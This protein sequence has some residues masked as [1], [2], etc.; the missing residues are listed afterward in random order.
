MQWTDGQESPL[1]QQLRA[2]A[3]EGQ[4]SIKFNVDGFDD[5]S[6][7]PTFTW[8]RIVGSIGPYQAGEPKHFVAARYLQPPG[9]RLA[10]EQRTVLARLGEQDAVRGP[11]QQ[12]ADGIGRRAAGGP[13][14]ARV[15]GSPIGG[16]LQVAALPANGDPG[17][18]GDTGRPGGFYEY[19]A[20]I[21]SAALSDVQLA[22][23][24]SEPNR[25]RRQPGAITLLAENA[26][27]T[28]LR[29]DDF[30][31][32]DGPERARQHRHDDAVRDQT[33]VPASGVEIDVWHNDVDE[34]GQVKQGSIAGMPRSACRP[35]RSPSRTRSRPA[36]TG[37]PPAA[38]HGEAAATRAGTST[39]RST[40]SATAG[41]ATT[42][43]RAAAGWACW[44]STTIRYP[45][46][47]PGSPTRCP[48]LQQYANLYP[49]MRDILDLSDYH[50]VVQRRR[51]LQLVF[52]LAVEDRTTCR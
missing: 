4:L 2:A 52:G 25:H 23:A 33:G 36:L 1:L 34:Q 12:P 19:Q 44:C 30:V 15:G 31:F 21:V 22:A 35:A 16:V 13:G 7:S 39:A 18:A 11:G 51:T 38:A 49:I 40:A 5:T 6:T 28:Y 29:A 41:A 14:C 24:R 3:H 9:A 37:Q 47:R 26:E 17:G 27:A 50:S 42:R 43:S 45:S 46:A 20:G 10:A 8:G 32:P 48:V